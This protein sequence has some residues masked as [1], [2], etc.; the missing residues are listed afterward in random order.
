MHFDSVDIRILVENVFAATFGMTVTP[1]MAVETWPPRRAAI[2]IVGTW[3]GH[4]VVATNDALLRASAA[5]MC[6]VPPRECGVGDLAD[7]LLELTNMIGGS[8]KSLLPEDCRLRVPN[9]L[10]STAAL[11]VGSQL[12]D[13]TFR[14]DGQPLRL[15]IVESPAGA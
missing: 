5:S 9:S 2:A 4:V 3:S 15:Q 12:V 10:A 13:R 8:V 11:P 14:C 7:A 6:L 1:A